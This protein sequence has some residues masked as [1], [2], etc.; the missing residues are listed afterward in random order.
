M[1]RAYSIGI[2]AVFASLAGCNSDV[3]NLVEATQES[4]PFT[5]SGRRVEWA[6]DSVG[7]FDRVVAGGESDWGELVA[8]LHHPQVRK[9]MWDHNG[10]QVAVID[11]ALWLS[12]TGMPKDLLNV[13]GS[14]ERPRGKDNVRQIVA[15]WQDWGSRG[16]PVTIHADGFQVPELV[17]YPD[18]ED[19]FVK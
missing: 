17:D 10:H 6:N 18:V 15:A 9:H 5:I 7:E 16:M 13:S 19:V 11:A 1:R 2:L 8:S 12:I 14:F 3:E 4:A